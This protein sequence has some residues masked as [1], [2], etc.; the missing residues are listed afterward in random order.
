MNKVISYL[1]CGLIGLGIGYLIW[2][3]DI[4]NPVD[5]QIHRLKAEIGWRQFKENKVKDSLKV[6]RKQKESL[7]K[8][9]SELRLIA[10]KAITKYKEA[11]KAIPLTRS[12][13]I[14][15]LVADTA[16]C[17]TALLRASE[18]ISGLSSEILKDNAII[19]NLDSL[20]SDLEEDKKELKEIDS[21]HIQTE[22]QL[23]K[24]GRKKFFKGLG[25]GG[26]LGVILVLLI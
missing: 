20:N 9:N 1:A 17:D 24:A 19:E 7:A 13:T 10:D 6:E 18:L 16:A 8:E 23:R 22:K 25:I 21:L 5:P 2:G 15:L 11:K 14:R 26:V 4:D 3:R 12:D